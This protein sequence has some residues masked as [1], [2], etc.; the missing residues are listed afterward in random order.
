L[1]PTIVHLNQEKSGGSSELQQR[2]WDLVQ[3]VLEEWTGQHLSPVSLYGIRLYHNNSILAPHVSQ[4]L[5]YNC[6]G[7]DVQVVDGDIN[8]VPHSFLMLLTI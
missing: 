5:F 1:Q 2:V 4:S 7:G 8:L 3:P 6:K